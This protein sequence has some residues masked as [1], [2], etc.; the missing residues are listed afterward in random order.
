MASPHCPLCRSMLVKVPDQGT[1]R[2]RCANCRKLFAVETGAQPAPTKPDALH[3]VQDNLVTRAL[4]ASDDVQDARETRQLEGE[5][6][7]YPVA[8]EPS[9]PP[10]AAP[11]GQLGRFQ[12][13]AVLGQGGFGTV[14]KAHDPALERTVALK[15]P[16]LAGDDAAQAQRFLAE[17]KAAACLRHPNIVTVFETGQAETACYIVSEFI[18]GAPLSV[19]L[20]RGLPPLR[21]AVRWVR[22]LARALSYAHGE[23]IVHRDVKPANIMIDRN[24]R[25][26][27]MDFGLARRLGSYDTREGEVV[28]TPAYMAPEQAAGDVRKIGPLCDQYALGAILY[29]LL[30]GQRPHEGS[31]HAVLAKLRHGEAP[32]PP[33]QVDPSVPRS[34]EAI[35]LKALA[36]VPAQRYFEMSGLA[37]DLQRWLNDEPVRAH[38]SGT[39]EHCRLWLRRQRLQSIAAC[40]ALTLIL[41]IAAGIY[42]G[43]ASRKPVRPDAGSIP[44]SFS[45]NNPSQFVPASPEAPAPAPVRDEPVEQCRLECSDLR[46][47]AAQLCQQEQFDR[48]VHLLARALELAQKADEVLADEVRLEL[49]EWEQKTFRLRLMLPK[50]EQAVG[51]SSDGRYVVTQAEDRAKNRDVW[52]TLVLVRDLDTGEVIGKP[53]RHDN[54]PFIAKSFVGAVSPDNRTILTRGPYKSNDLHLWR[55]QTGEPIGLPLHHDAPPSTWI[56]SP[57]G[58]R[59][60]TVTGKVLRLWN[61]ESG[62]LAGEP[63]TF[64]EPVLDATFSPSDRTFL[65]HCRTAKG[66]PQQH[67]ILLHDADTLRQIGEAIQFPSFSGEKKLYTFSPDGRLLVLH[68]SAKTLHLYHTATG[69]T[70]GQPLV[71]GYPVQAVVVHPDGKTL[72]VHV[73]NERAPFGTRPGTP[74]VDTTPRAQLWDLTGGEAANRVP[75]TGLRELDEVLRLVAKETGPGAMGPPR[76][77]PGLLTISPDGRTLLA[78]EDPQT[79]RLWDAF[80]GRPIGSLIQHEAQRGQVLFS[81]DGR[82]LFVNSRKDNEWAFVGRLYDAATGQPLGQPL[83]TSARDAVGPFSPEG[84]TLL[85][86]DE[87]DQCRLWSVVPRQPIFLA[88]HPQTGLFT[89]YGDVELAL[90]ADGGT[91]LARD[92]NQWVLK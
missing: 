1:R 70:F 40:A 36:R 14:Y 63:L 54:R 56:F 65:V 12:L 21:L 17:A 22:D 76:E 49:A 92:R 19:K 91:V 7:A 45:A 42:L 64:P 74:P 16:K 86:R 13:L 57:G 51:F 8:E 26:L 73:Q 71:H 48:G 25:P 68:Q 31:T 60:L 69:M 47:R 4:P 5:E 30:T 52:D 78:T 2:W 87:M 88:P 46:R 24:N 20:E 39:L 84:Q 35:C 27:L 82:L 77:Y 33:R 89:W 55:M 37:K 67:L 61:T 18:E 80:T 72:L 85:L 15:V 34:L 41:L 29:E 11:L 23:G 3:D 79:L 6:S 44:S 53:I 58:K 83:S 50:E 81:P 59:L 90:S 66:T 32:P 43:F 9:A 75:M 62:K 10:P 38:R 28:G